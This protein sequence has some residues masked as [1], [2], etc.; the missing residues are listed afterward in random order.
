[1]AGVH[2][3]TII[4]IHTQTATV[5]MGPPLT[6]PSG[7]LLAEIMKWQSLRAIYTPPFIIEQWA[8][9]ANS[10]KLAKEIDFVLFGG[11]PLAPSIGHEL[12]KVTNVCQ[13][14]G[15]L[16]TGQIQMLMPQPGEWEYLEPN[17]YEECDMQQVDDGIYEMVLH[18]EPRFRQQRSLAHNFPDVKTWRT[19][20]LF[21]P[22]PS[23]PGL[24]RFH[25]RLDD[26]IVLSSSHKLRPLDLETILQGNP[27][28]SAAL[29]TGNGRPEPLLIVEPALAEAS[30]PKGDFIDKIWPSV[31]EANSVAPTYGRI[32]R[33]RILLSR[34][35]IPFV[36]TT[37]GTVARKA[38]E[39][40]YAE[41]IANVF[42]C[43]S[44]AQCHASGVL[45]SMLLDAVKGFIRTALRDIQP[46][47]MLQDDD[48]FFSHQGICSLTVVELAQKI[49]LGLSPRLQHEDGPDMWL[50][51]I[52]ENSSIN[53]L[54]QATFKASIHGHDTQNGTV[55][56]NK[57]DQMRDLF[58]E[59]GADIPNMAGQRSSF[60]PTLPADGIN[61]MLLGAR[62]RLGPYMVRELLQDPRVASIICLNRGDNG[63]ER[64][65][66]VVAEQ[67]LDIDAEDQRL[68]F[69]HADLS[70]PNLGL[71][72][73]Q[74]ADI[75][76]NTH[77]I[78]HNVW[79]VD[80]SLSVKSYK[81]ELLKSVCTTIDLSAKAAHRPRVIFVSSIASIQDWEIVYP[82]SAAP[83]EPVDSYDVA[84]HTGYGQSKNVAEKLLALGAKEISVPV[85]VLRLGQ[86]APAT[87]GNGGK[88]NS[89]DWLQCMALLSKATSH[90]P[91][92]MG[93]IDWV[94]VDTMSKMM[95]EMMLKRQPDGQFVPTDND[96]Q[97]LEVYN[98]VHPRPIP[99]AKFAD[100]L[101]VRFGLPFARQIPFCEWVRLLERVNPDT[102]SIEEAW[103]RAL[104]LPFFQRLVEKEAT[105]PSIQTDKAQKA[106]N[107]MAAMPAVDE[108]MMNWWC[109]QWI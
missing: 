78:I 96:R 77:V 35:D 108:E 17:P 83:E 33:S 69:Y 84:W 3:Y 28:I 5:V 79:R 89:H 106:S 1:M 82:N 38:T 20:D 63:R 36:R 32:R 99:F 34:P 100:V 67:N 85:T 41:D 94:P 15:S 52:Y 98:L 55:L 103:I 65:E 45:E 87:V 93:P 56:P 58:Q 74:L 9:D 2:A 70:N 64:F 11:G 6:P 14:Y 19:K 95:C 68:Q 53:S 10:S 75:L 66:K 86:V 31:T 39:T 22:H 90:I 97:L 44:H 26:M 71:S 54:A 21:V 42:A 40:L 73:E 49:R 50:R 7:F 102:L 107:T 61:I 4:P 29:I 43:D 104:I 76:S 72:E 25:S 81:P 51:M 101:Q 47:L 13:M 109:E 18:Q 48:D 24:W 37:K 16:E 57:A 23:K 8:S 27:C 105:Y 12:S 88:W 46:D 91:D 80:F 92:N 30:T 62:G 60:P 59:L